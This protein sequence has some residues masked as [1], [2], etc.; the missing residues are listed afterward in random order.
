MKVSSSSLSHT[1]YTLRYIYYSSSLHSRGC[2]KRSHH[3]RHHVAKCTATVTTSVP[4]IVSGRLD[5][6]N[7][8]N[9]RWSIQVLGITARTILAGI[10]ELLADLS[11]LC[12]LSSRPHSPPAAAA[13]AAAATT[14]LQ[15]QQ[16]Q[17]AVLLEVLCRPLDSAITKTNGTRLSILLR[18]HTIGFWSSHSYPQQQQQ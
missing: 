8:T 2:V 3:S 4:G 1:P 13:A 12:R 9:T 15:Q 18:G 17:R 14:T 6:T 5:R 16:Q 10:P 7:Q 11:R